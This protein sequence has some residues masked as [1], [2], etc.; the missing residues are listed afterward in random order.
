MLYFLE[1]IFPIKTLMKILFR[2]IHIRN[3]DLRLLFHKFHPGWT[4]FLIFNTTLSSIELV[5]KSEI[6]CA[7]PLTFQFSQ[8]V[9]KL[10]AVWNTHVAG[11]NMKISPTLGS[12]LLLGILYSSNPTN[13]QIIYKNTWQL[14]DESHKT[15]HNQREIILYDFHRNIK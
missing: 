11:L 15:I 4:G 10:K 14:Q 2:V 1:F 9:Y 6:P 12:I 7:N 8:V 5:E 3:I 13:T